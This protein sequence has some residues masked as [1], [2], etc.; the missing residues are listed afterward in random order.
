[1]LRGSSPSATVEK[2]IHPVVRHIL[3]EICG[4]AVNGIFRTLDFQ[5]KI[6]GPLSMDLSRADAATKERLAR[7][8]FADLSSG[9]AVALRALMD[10]LVLGANCGSDRLR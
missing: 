10:R 5:G 4:K 7:D 9:S 6:D 8:P 1:V 2:T 3:V